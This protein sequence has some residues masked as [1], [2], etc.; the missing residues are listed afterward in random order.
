M[1]GDPGYHFMDLFQPDII[2]HIDDFMPVYGANFDRA[3]GRYCLRTMPDTRRYLR[4]GALVLVQ[5]LD[6][7]APDDS[8]RPGS[9]PNLHKG[10][11]VG[12]D[13]RA[14]AL[15]KGKAAQKP[16]RQPTCQTKAM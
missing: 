13:M 7:A 1:K 8:Q 4:I 11:P 5:S 3:I 9:H 14:R 12:L 15:G 6:D 10:V 2:V 16:N